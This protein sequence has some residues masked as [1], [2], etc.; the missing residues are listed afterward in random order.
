MRNKKLKLLV[1]GVLMILVASAS[2]HGL[3]TLAT[4]K[5]HV[6]VKVSFPV[7]SQ[8]SD[9]EAFVEKMRS[10]VH[11]YEGLDGLISKFYVLSEDNRRAG[12][13]Y[14]WESIGKANEW[15]TTE[16]Y[17]YMKSAWGEP[18]TVEY[19]KTPIIVQNIQ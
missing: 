14:L 5:G 6:V 15:Y 7:G 9:V 12:G 3:D 18:P 17:D 19:L 4:Y 11:K 2:G 10:T 1:F 8:S 13:L 16:W